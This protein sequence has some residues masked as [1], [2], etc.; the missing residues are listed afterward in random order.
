MPSQA[1]LEKQREWK[2]LIERQ[3]QSGLSIEKW[4]LQN[5]LR[6]HTFHYWR[7]KL[8]PKQLQK[9]NFTEL[10][11]KKL[12]TTIS[13]QTHGVCI[14]IDSDCDPNIRRQL[15]AL[16]VG[17][18]CWHC[19]ILVFFYV[20]RQ[21]VCIGALKGSAPLWSN[22][23]QESCFQGL[24]FFSWTNSATASKCFSGIEMG[25]QFGTNDS[26]EDRLFAIPKKTR[27]T[28][29]NY[30]CFW[31]ESNPKKSVQNCSKNN[32]FFIWK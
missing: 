21:S 19:Q 13:L 20:I 8:F 27:W 31:K 12:D 25:L 17:G 16:F 28:G 4:C 14:R 24:S 26:K 29:E 22:Y 23:F 15:F 10:K 2:A 18:S 11:T 1:S 6:P 5:Q 32:G 7:D 30:W 9:S 3:K